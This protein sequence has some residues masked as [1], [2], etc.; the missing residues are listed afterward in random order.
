[1]LRVRG[2]LLP[3]ERRVEV[4]IDGSTILDVAEPGSAAPGDDVVEAAFIIPGLVDAH[5][6]CGIAPGLGVTI[7]KARELARQD[8]LAGTLLIREVGSPLDTHPLD[9]D[10]AGP[11]FQRAGRHIARTKRYLRGYGVELDDPADLPD[12]VE[13]QAQAGDGWVKL[14]GDWIDRDVGDLAPLWPDDV[15]RVAVERAHSAGAKVTAHVFGT[16]ALPG[17]IAAGVDCIEHGTGLT[18]DL[19]DE[20]ARRGTSLVPT[21]IQVDTFPSI[22]AGADRFPAYKQHMLDLFAGARAAF[23]KAR[24]AG[25]TMYAGTDAGGFQPHGRIV[26]EIAE[27]AGIGLGAETAVARACWE[28]RAWLGAPGVDPGARADLIALSADPRRDV[29]TLREPVAIVCGG[30]RLR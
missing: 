29:A 23:A 26:D 14:V 30:V 12:E 2:T 16:D 18:D 11:R 25:I 28:S 24:E 27:L 9:D 6:H 19:I 8:A 15:L 22:A 7:E 5:N 10:V 1:M 13:R 21:L 4:V 3:E 17:L 20:M